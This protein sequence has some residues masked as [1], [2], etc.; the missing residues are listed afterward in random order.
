MSS[1]IHSLIPQFQHICI[2]VSELL[3]HISVGKNIKTTTVQ[4]STVLMCNAFCLQSYRFHSFLKL[5]R[6]APLPLCLSVIIVSY[7][8]NTARLFLI[9]F[10]L[11]PQIPRHPKLF[12]NLHILRFTLCSMGCDKCIVRYPQL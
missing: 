9:T 12:F 5:H 2:V 4:Y 1:S 6:S 11:Y 10:A 7:I 8:C 3:T